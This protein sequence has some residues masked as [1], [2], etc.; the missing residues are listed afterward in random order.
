[1]PA[2]AAA[3]RHR[4]AA[5]VALAHHLHLRGAG[6]DLDAAPRHHRVEQVPAIVGLQFQQ[7]LV[8]DGDGNLASPGRAAIGAGHA[9]FRLDLFAHVIFWLVGRHLHLQ[10]MSRPAGLEFGRAHAESGL[11]QIDHG[12]GRNTGD[13]A[14]HGQRADEDIRPV[15]RL[16]GHFDHGRI[17]LDFGDPG[18]EHTFAFH[19]DQ[20]RGGFEGQGHAQ[21]RG[22]ADVVFTFLR[23]QVHAVVVGDLHPAVR[24]GHPGIGMGAAFV[25]IGILCARLQNQIACCRGFHLT[26]QPAQVIGLACAGVGHPADFAPMRI[27]IKT[28]D[29]P[30]AVA[31]PVALEDFGFDVHARR[32]LAAHVH[33]L[34]GE[35]QPIFRQ[36]PGIRLDRQQNGSRV[37]RNA[38]GGGQCF[39]IGVAVFQFRQQVARRFAGG[40]VCD[41]DPRCAACVE[42]E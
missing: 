19:A 11:S 27:G 8:D 17:A 18:I 13:A 7:A 41:G 25:A 1:M 37:E 21:F 36:Q 23:H 33:S 10:R 31:V 22:F 35:F 3:R 28:A 29:Q 39:A 5:I 30:L 24:A 15:V 42:L 32:R 34:H 6:F 9:D 14:T 26:G 20:H 12:G 16:D 4:L 40:Q 2:A 38:R